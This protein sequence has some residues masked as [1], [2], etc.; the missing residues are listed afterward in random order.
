MLIIESTNLD[1][2]FSFIPNACPYLMALLI[3]LLRTYPCS[4]LLGTIPSEII[5][6]EDFNLN[7]KNIKTKTTITNGYVNF[8]IDS[9]IVIESEGRSIIYE[10]KDNPIKKSSKLYGILEIA[11]YIT[12]SHREDPNMICINCLAN[13]AEERNV[14]VDMLDFIDNSTLIVISENSSY[15]NPYYFEFL[16]KY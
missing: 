1:V 14:Y 11:K 2:K 5:K 6:I 13:M 7:Y 10:L 4:V 16:N 3:N 15:E 9:S 12:D 8:L